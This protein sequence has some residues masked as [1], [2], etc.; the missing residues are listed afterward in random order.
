MKAR[1]AQAN[2][3]RGLLS[4]FEVV[5][6]QGIGR[7]GLRLPEILDDGETVPSDRCA[8]C[9]RACWRSSCGPTSDSEN[10]KD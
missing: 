4:E 7:L 3:I 2:Q 10:T 9:S 8:P 5:L 6:A 1:N